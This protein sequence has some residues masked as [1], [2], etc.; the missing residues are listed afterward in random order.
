[1]ELIA[2]MDRHR[3][4]DPVDLA[5]LEKQKYYENLEEIKKVD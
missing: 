2:M 1:M 5:E 4:R 3:K